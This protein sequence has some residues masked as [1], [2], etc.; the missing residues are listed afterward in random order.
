MIISGENYVWV[1][2][3]SVIENAQAHAKFPVGMLGVHFD[4]SS[5]ALNSYI[6]TALN[7]YVQAVQNFLNDPINLRRGGLNTNNLSCQEEGKARW[8]NGET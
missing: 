2:T 8:E 5:S 1:V 4:T 6:T 7:V 3:Q